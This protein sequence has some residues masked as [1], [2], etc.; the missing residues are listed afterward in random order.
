MKIMVQLTTKRAIEFGRNETEYLCD[1]DVTQ[2]SKDFRNLL[3]MSI[4]DSSNNILNNYQLL[5]DSG[6]ITLDSIKIAY[7]KKITDLKKDLDKR[8]ER[9][10]IALE[11]LKTNKTTYH[12]IDCLFNLHSDQH[13]LL[14]EED[15][16]KMCLLQDEIKAIHER[17]LAEENKKRDEFLVEYEKRITEYENG[18]VYPTRDNT[19]SIPSDL[20]KRIVAQNYKV[21][22]A[23]E[24]KVAEKRKKM[25]DEIVERY[26]TNIQKRRY[27]AGFMNPGDV[28]NL[29]WSNIFVCKN[30]FIPLSINSCKTEIVYEI[31]PEDWD[32]DESQELTDEQFVKLEQVLKSYEGF[33]YTVYCESSDLRYDVPFVRLKT[34][35]YDCTLEADFIL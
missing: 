24:K 30:G 14:P 13:R 6:N 1:I 9:A 32:Y 11:K 22:T 3:A 29:L 8:V 33:E 35:E 16:K 25:D 21:K 31:I 10:R 28:F 5:D 34:F 20:E 27:K 23:T 18:G 2:L 4:G 15:T 26:G 19:Y 7:E 17:R 12:S